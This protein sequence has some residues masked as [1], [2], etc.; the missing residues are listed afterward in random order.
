MITLDGSEEIFGSVS[1]RAD[2]EPAAPRMVAEI[3]AIVAKGFFMAQ[4]YRALG[5]RGRVC[6][7]KL[8][9]CASRAGGAPPTLIHDGSRPPV[10]SR[11]A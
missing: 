10:A 2:G 4:R 7:E 6:R 5:V 3:S 8:H 9:R 11:M 1:A